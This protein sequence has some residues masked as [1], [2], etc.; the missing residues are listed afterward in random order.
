MQDYAKNEKRKKGR[1]LK[2]L[3]PEDR[4]EIE[5]GLE[6]NVSIRDIAKK[7]KRNVSTIYSEISRHGGYRKYNAEEAIKKAEKIKE[8]KVINFPPL[9][10]VIKQITPRVTTL[11]EKVKDLE[12]QIELL[13]NAIRGIYDKQN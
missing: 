1:E 4:K 2:F 9:F 7:L 5:S 13:H 6:N 10:S 11:E 12:E 3:T 8:Q